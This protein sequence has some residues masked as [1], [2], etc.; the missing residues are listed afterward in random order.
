[1][2]VVHQNHPSPT[3]ICPQD[4][5]ISNFLLVQIPVELRNSQI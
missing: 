3:E 2:E 5:I 1:M 4:F